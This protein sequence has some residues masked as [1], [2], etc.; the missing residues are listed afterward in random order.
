MGRTPTVS[1]RRAYLAPATFLMGEDSLRR[2]DAGDTKVCKAKGTRR[3]TL[4]EMER[5]RQGLEQDIRRLTDAS[6]LKHHLLRNAAEY[7]TA[8]LN[9]AVA[10]EV[11]RRNLDAGRSR[12][13]DSFLVL[14]NIVT[15][16]SARTG[17]GLEWRKEF[18]VQGECEERR[19]LGDFACYLAFCSA[20]A[21]R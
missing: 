10:D 3:M 8:R 6:A 9:W 11:E 17:A 18:G 15:R 12:T 16:Q 2:C 13:H 1:D 14:L 7:L 20:I 19:A 4:D 21:A 5:A